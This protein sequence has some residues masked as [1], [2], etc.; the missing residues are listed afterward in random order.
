M[1]Q[2]LVWQGMPRQQ[3]DSHLEWPDQ[4]L[5]KDFT[6]KVVQ[7]IIDLQDIPLVN[8]LSGLLSTRHRARQWG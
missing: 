6:Q 7:K 1:K 4:T 5:G 3:E 8:Q 2:A